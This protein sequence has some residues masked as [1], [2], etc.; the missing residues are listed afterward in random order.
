MFM[1]IG[2]AHIALDMH[3]IIHELKALEVE[4]VQL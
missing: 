4:T 1:Q 2:F 3:R